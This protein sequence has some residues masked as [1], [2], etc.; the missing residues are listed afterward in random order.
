MFSEGL[1]WWRPNDRANAR[2]LLEANVAGAVVAIN[3]GH[4]ADDHQDKDDDVRRPKHKTDPVEWRLEA[5]L[6]RVADDM[7]LLD[8][9]EVCQRRVFWEGI[10]LKTP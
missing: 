5:R 4:A 8:Q 9:E 10:S 6:G 7:Y 3:V 2:K 1:D